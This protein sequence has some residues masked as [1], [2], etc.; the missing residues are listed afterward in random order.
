MYAVVRFL[1]DHDNRLHVIHVDDIDNFEPKDINDFDNRAI[2]SA[3]WMDPV[4]DLNSGLYD[5]QVLMLAVERQ[6][7]TI[8]TEAQAPCSRSMF[9]APCLPT[10]AEALGTVGTPGEEPQNLAHAGQ[11][12]DFSFMNNGSRGP[13]DKKC[14]GDHL[15]HK[16]SAWRR[17]EASPNT[18]EAP[19][20]VSFFPLA[21]RV[22]IDGV[23]KETKL[24]AQR[25]QECEPPCSDALQAYISEDAPGPSRVF[26]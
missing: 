6:Q 23:R 4:D 17:A 15:L 21:L 16:E 20:C 11:S 26:Q 8:T 24:T 5:T 2:Y 10:A 7:D 18:R 12:R 19:R 9:A 13:H 25:L 1:T 14:H 3:F 22:F